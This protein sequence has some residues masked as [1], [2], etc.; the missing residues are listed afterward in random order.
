MNASRT[1][2]CHFVKR[3][4]AGVVLLL[5]WL[6]VTF[7]LKADADTFRIEIDYMG[8]PVRGGH[9][10]EPSAAV[11]E[12]VQQMF[13]CQGHTLIIDL[14]DEVPHY[15]ILRR[16]PNSC[17]SSLFNYS[18]S[19]DSYGAIKASYYDHSGQ[20][21]WHYC[22]FAHQYENRSCA[23]TSS[24]GLAEGVND[25]IVTLGAF[26]GQTGTTFSQAATLAH[27]FGHN[28]GLSHCGAMYCGSDTSAANYVGPYV[29]N[30]ASVMSYRYQLAGVRANMLCNGLTFEEAL[31][32]NIDYSHGRMCTLNE[33]NLNEVLGTQMMSVDWD[34]DGVLEGSVAQDINGDRN[35]WCGPTGNR[36]SLADYSEWA[37]LNDGSVLAVA[38]RSQRTE[39]SCITAEEWEDVQR[40]LSLRGGCAQPALTTEGCIA[41]KNIYI[42]NL[43]FF[44]FGTCAFPYDSVQQAHDAAPNHSV[45]HIRPRTYDETGTVI[46]DKPGKYFCN[47]GSAVIR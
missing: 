14:S 7:A 30:L 20:T 8:P 1:S 19:N 38:E 39:T 28:L 44:E 13:A 42:G 15:N 9:S 40:E 32:K 3:V 33:D 46:L 18:G 34:C 10:H 2:C 17:G 36:T 16:N 5:P 35:G 24:S 47:T 26:S 29:P 43:Y 25:F 31:F 21:G 11:I 27:E 4:I 37:S 12:A 6:S 45:F 41:G 23:K 22:I